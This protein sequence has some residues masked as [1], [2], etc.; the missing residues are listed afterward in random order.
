MAEEPTR[1]KARFYTKE[2]NKAGIYLMFFFINGRETPVY[3]DEHIPVLREGLNRSGE[4]M[5]R[6][7]NNKLWVVL[8]EKAWA[9]IC[10][11][12]ARTTGGVCGTAAEHILG[13]TSETL[14]HQNL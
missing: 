6:I 9:K 5:A 7:H 2:R 1:V 8:M 10:G 12:Y 11:T 14:Y 13:V 4:F 3:V